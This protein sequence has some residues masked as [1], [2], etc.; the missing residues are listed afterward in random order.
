MLRRYERQLALKNAGITEQE[1]VEFAAAINRI[2][3]RLKG[4]HAQ[5]ANPLKVEETLEKELKGSP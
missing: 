4:P 1:L 5:P 3:E 2:D